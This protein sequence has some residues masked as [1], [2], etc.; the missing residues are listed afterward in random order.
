MFNWLLQYILGYCTEWGLE[1]IGEPPLTKPLPSAVGKEPMPVWI[2]PI[3]FALPTGRYI[4]SFLVSFFLKK[5]FPPP[6]E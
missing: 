4:S 6:D 3:F 1:A 2:I 5:I